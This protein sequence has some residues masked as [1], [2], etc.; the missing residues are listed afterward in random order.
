MGKKKSKEIGWRKATEMLLNM[1]SSQKIA[2]LYEV[3]EDSKYYYV[4][5]EKVQGRDL[6]ELL[7]A[8]RGKNLPLALAKPI[9]KELL[10]AVD[11]LHQ[12]DCIHKDIKLEN[13][14]ADLGS[15]SS[16]SSPSPSSPVVKLIDF[17]TVQTIEES[18]R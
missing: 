18:S 14:M 2:K 5:M 9:L 6:F 11:D 1:P 7:Q 15:V 4:V 10:T 8:H 17:D 16:V 12:R 3:L 13:V